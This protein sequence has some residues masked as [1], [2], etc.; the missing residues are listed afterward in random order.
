M[1][2]LDTL[3]TDRTQ[4]D[5]DYVRSLSAKGIPQMSADELTEFLTTLKG[6][7][8]YSDLNRV[9]TA[10]A[11]VA[12]ELVQAP[13]DLRQYASDRNVAWDD[14]FD[15]PYDPDDYDNLTIKTNWAVSDIPTNLQ[16]IRYIEN[17][18]LIRDAI[19]NASIAWIPDVMDN[20][21][22]SIANN[23]EQLMIDVHQALIALVALK[24][25]YI[26]SAMEVSYSGEVYSGEEEA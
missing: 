21:D 24:E 15:V 22:Y 1:S 20:L 19:P 5:V 6:A 4:A 14:L 10:V 26:R 16:M 12:A 11:Y 2:V 3:I 13:T 7:Y 23:I 8:N 18:K 25:G 9:E 17:I